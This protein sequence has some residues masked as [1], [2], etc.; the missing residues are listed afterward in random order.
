MIVIAQGLDFVSRLR[1]VARKMNAVKDEITSLTDV[2]IAHGLSTN[3]TVDHLAGEHAGLDLAEV[4]DA[5][6]VLGQINTA[7]KAGGAASQMNKLLKIS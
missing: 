7:Y 5:V 4:K 1:D 6:T 3:L 2:Y